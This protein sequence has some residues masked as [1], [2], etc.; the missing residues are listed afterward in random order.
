ML[1]NVQFRSILPILSEKLLHV[2]VINKGNYWSIQSRTSDK[3]E[4]G[5]NVRDVVIVVIH[6]FIHSVAS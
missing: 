2:D 6:I 4:Q 1:W 3:H 5:H